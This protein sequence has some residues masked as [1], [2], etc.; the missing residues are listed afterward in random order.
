MKIAILSTIKGYV[1]GGTEEV[2]LH[3]ATRA[4]E[5]GHEVMVGAD[6]QVIGSDQCQSLLAAGLQTSSR[7]L[8]RP[9]RL[10]TL[11]NRFR[12][13]HQKLLAFQPDV[14]LINSGSPYD[15]FYNG[16]LGA[17][18][19]KIDCKK[20]F[21]CHFN[22]DRLIVPDRERSRTLFGEMDHVVFVNQANHWN[23]EMQL[24]SRVAP[25]T[26]ILNTTRLILP[27]P[28]PFPSDGPVCFANV[29]RLE[30]GWKGQ[31]LLAGLIG[32]PRWKE[33][34]CRVDCFGLGPDEKYI[35]DLIMMNGCGERMR[36]CGYLR[37]LKS[38]WASHHALLLPS[39]GEGTPLVA[40]EAMM[41]GRPVISTDVG[42]NSEIIE[43]G[44]TGYLAEA[45]TLRSFGKAMNRAWKEREKWPEMGRAAHRKATEL[46][47][48][49][50]PG[51]LL[52]VLVKV[53]EGTP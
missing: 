37:D 43:D 15:L 31:D 17:L 21:F 36:L 6:H 52:E 38:L 27:G 16:N 46:A 10:H 48:A 12:D 47:Q 9:R 7:R 4:L 26:V 13:D 34:D 18:V 42:G 44:V 1:W 53:V 24:A 35:Q 14:L 45:P 41:C 3:L 2:W 39:R 51:R 22:S 19:G 29:A 28:M 30:T 32:E 20:V 11:K 8:F 40:I 33:R 50:P 5:Q 49:D 23:L 25:S